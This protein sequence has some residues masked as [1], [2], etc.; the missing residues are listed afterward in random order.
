MSNELALVVYGD[1]ELSVLQMMARIEEDE[2]TNRKKE[3]LQIKDDASKNVSPPSTGGVYI[4]YSE[5]L[6][7]MKIGATRRSDP[8][9]RLH[10]ISRYTTTPFRLVAWRPSQKPFTLEAVAHFHFRKQRI[11]TRGA[12]AGTEFFHISA[13]EAVE[14]VDQAQVDDWTSGRKRK[15]SGAGVRAGYNSKKGRQA[16]DNAV[17]PMENE[18]TSISDNY[19]QSWQEDFPGKKRK[20][21]LTDPMNEKLECFL[22]QH[23]KANAKGFVSSKFILTEYE[24]TESII[25]S[26]TDGDAFRRYLKQFIARTF[27]HNDWKCK[28]RIYGDEKSRQQGYKGISFE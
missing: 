20:A 1:I 25:L 8:L 12:E 27:D 5:C 2:E 23:L 19:D 16:K 10:E 11:N 22:Q 17:Q 26:Y 15:A 7:C 4:A 24:K 3:L 6:G 21:P 13:A 28:R 9:I 14:W 18:T